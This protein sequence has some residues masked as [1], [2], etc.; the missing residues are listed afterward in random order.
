MS[1]IVGARL[2][3]YFAFCMFRYLMSWGDETWDKSKKPQYF[4]HTPG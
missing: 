4:A 1:R 2:F 3:A